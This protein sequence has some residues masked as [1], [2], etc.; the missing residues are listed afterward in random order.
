M[1]FLIHQLAKQCYEGKSIAKKIESL[2]LWENT[3]QCALMMLFVEYVQQSLPKEAK[4]QKR[5]ESI[6]AKRTDDVIIIWDGVFPELQV[7]EEYIN[8]N[9]RS[10]VKYYNRLMTDLNQG[11]LLKN[12][13]SYNNFIE[14][15]KKNLK[16]ECHVFLGI[17]KNINKI[18]SFEN[19]LPKNDKVL[20]SV[21][22][23]VEH[24][25]PE[26][27]IVLD[28]KE[29]EKSLKTNSTTLETAS[30]KSDE[31]KKFNFSDD[32]ESND[33]EDEGFGEE[34]AAKKTPRKLGD[35]SQQ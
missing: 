11:M 5:Q 14:N 9:K 3:L 1:Q 28:E 24:F 15:F 29:E 20:Y 7:Q 22:K 18:D 31:N 33:E 19:I 17:P 30:S 10:L 13:G 12:S 26:S 8:N 27:L 6:D 34:I 21:S 32:E 25:C 16:K 35:T 23:A 2:R 4:S